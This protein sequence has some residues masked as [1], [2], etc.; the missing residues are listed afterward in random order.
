MFVFIVLLLS[1]A[2]S[3]SFSLKGTDG[4]SMPPPWTRQLYLDAEYLTGSDVLIMCT[5][6]HRDEAVQ[7]Q[8]G[9]VECDDI[10]DIQD[11]TDVST[12][13]KANN[14]DTTGVFEETTANLLLQLH[15]ADGYKDNGFT[16]ASMGYLYKIHV[17]VHENRS[18]ETIGTLFDAYNNVLL[19]FPV[20][21]HGHR[22]DCSN[23]ACTWPDFGD[24]DY[25]LNQFTT[26]GNSVTGLIEVDLN[27]GEEPTDLYGPWPVNRY[28]RGLEGNAQLLLP[29]IRDGILL[30]TGNWTTD[31]HGTWDPRTMNMP[32]SAGCHHSHPIYVETIYKILTVE[33]GVVVNDNPFSGKNYPYKPQGIAVVELID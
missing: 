32:N 7:A 16:A 18:I 10:F 20:R 19:N 31:D 14:L 22:E 5:L 28:V 3:S 29:N 25:G 23:D 26:N 27:S 2:S 4:S 24:G 33:L 15:S 30:H 21:N 11:E 9:G 13:Q 6:L 8:T 17:P 1:T 12:F